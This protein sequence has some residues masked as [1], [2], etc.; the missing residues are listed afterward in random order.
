MGTLPNRLIK[1]VRTCILNRFLS[2]NKKNNNYFSSENF[3]FFSEK[4]TM[5]LNRR[6][7]VMENI[8]IH[9]TLLTICHNQIE[10]N[11]CHHQQLCNIVESLRQN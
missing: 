4:I 10:S 7:F 8:I 5:Y 1:A 6:V 11:I 2:R 3:P 9:S